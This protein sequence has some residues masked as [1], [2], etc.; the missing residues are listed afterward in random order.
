VPSRGGIEEN[1]V[2]IHGLQVAEVS[3]ISGE[4]YWM[5]CAKLI[6]SS[7]P[8]TWLISSEMKICVPWSREDELPS[9][10][11]ASWILEWSI[12]GSIS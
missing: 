10:R 9:K 6:A 2:E 1:Q 7:I 4:W 11:P 8:G 3:K 5:S 12:F